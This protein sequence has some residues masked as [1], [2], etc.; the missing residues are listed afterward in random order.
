MN[1]RFLSFL[2]L[3]VLVS[4]CKINRTVNHDRVGK[5]IYKDTVNGILYKSKG[6]YK[7]SIE[8][9]TWKYYENRK[10]VKT[11]KYKDGICYITTFDS[12]GHI[13]STGQSMMVEEN[14]ETHWYIIGEWTFF[15]KNGKV[16]GIKKYEK[17]ELVSVQEFIPNPLR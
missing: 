13:T 1:W 7:K 12:E 3:I 14:E 5:W 8:I 15:D 17:G 11:E 16:I 9:K 6:R 2:M 4:S 10:L